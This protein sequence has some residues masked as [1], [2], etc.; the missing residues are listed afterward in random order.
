MLL[1]P[2]VL[3]PNVELMPLI[4]TDL[5][6]ICKLALTMSMMRIYFVYCSTISIFFNSVLH[7]LVLSKYLL[8]ETGKF[9]QNRLL[10]WFINSIRLIF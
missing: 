3:S 10:N 7:T 6:H 2:S 1:S 8:D 4:F 5:S 9:L